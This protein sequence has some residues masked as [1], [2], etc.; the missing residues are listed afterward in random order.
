MLRTVLI[1]LVLGAVA[2]LTR[3]GPDNFETEMKRQLTLAV[4]EAEL[5]EECVTSPAFRDG[6]MYIRGKEH[7]F[8]IGTNGK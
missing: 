5:G 4:A 6:R 2:W 1:L 8:C 7:V 3:P